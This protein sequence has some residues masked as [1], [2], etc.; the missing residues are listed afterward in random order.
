M[1]WKLI[2]AMGCILAGVGVV[3]AFTQGQQFLGIGQ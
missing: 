2:I 1:D 3:I